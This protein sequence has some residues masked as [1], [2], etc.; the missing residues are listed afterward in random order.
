MNPSRIDNLTDA[1]FGIAITLL[2]FNLLNPNSF[3]DLLVFTKTLPAFLI[4]IT[5]LIL[6]WAEHIRFSRIF[7]LNNTGLMVLNTLFIALVIFY[8]YPLRF[9]TLF[10]TSVFFDTNVGL[11]IE[12]YQVPFLMIYYGTA[13]FALYFILFLFYRKAQKLKE[14]LDLNNFELF[15]IKTQ[16]S[17]LIIMFSIPLLS[18]LITAM[19]NHYSYAWASFAGG[20][21]YMLYAPAMIIWQRNYSKNSK[22]LVKE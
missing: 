5:F 9:L 16:K 19:V 18:V 8:V 6:F 11:S 7:T 15:I 2:V 12:G 20:V 10:L 13:A 3:N 22:K 17:K 14:E 21:I 1:V 4:S